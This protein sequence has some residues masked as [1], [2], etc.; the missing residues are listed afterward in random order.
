[1]SSLPSSEGELVDTLMIIVLC[2]LP[3]VGPLLPL[4]AVSPLPRPPLP[5][6]APLINFL[7]VLVAAV[8]AHLKINLRSTQNRRKNEETFKI[9][10][11]QSKNDT[12]WMEKH[13]WNGFGA[14]TRQMGDLVQAAGATLSDY[15]INF[16]SGNPGN[17]NKIPS[18]K[19]MKKSAPKKMKIIPKRCQNGI[20]MVPKRI[21]IQ[22]KNR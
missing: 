8:V 10:R 17:S 16:R 4:L 22:Y 5:P 20:E 11:N 1:M 13:R 12:K 21:T 14:E 6:L 7:G 15:G 9:I 3:W 18:E 19:H 2:G